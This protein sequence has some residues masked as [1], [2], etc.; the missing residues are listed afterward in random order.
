V[1]AA[2]GRLVAFAGIQAYGAACGDGALADYVVFVRPL[3]VGDDGA[4]GAQLQALFGLTAAETALALALRRDSE[5]A[6]AAR[7]VGIAEG[8]AR[9]RLQAVYD[10]TGQHRQAELLRM[11]DA[12]ADTLD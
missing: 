12:L 2:D 7:A 11:L 6:S 8:S 3:R 4:L 10:K 1:H 5:L 9:T